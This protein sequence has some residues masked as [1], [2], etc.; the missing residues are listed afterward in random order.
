MKNE[1]IG[2]HRVTKALCCAGK[3]TAVKTHYTDKKGRIRISHLLIILP[4]P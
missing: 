4:P 3:T 1:R 2:E